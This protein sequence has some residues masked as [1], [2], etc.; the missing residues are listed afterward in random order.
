MVKYYL[1]EDAGS[2]EDCRVV[3]YSDKGRKFMERIR[4][5]FKE[6]NKLCNYKILM[7]VEE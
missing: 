5:V 2:L 7:E 1:V 4:E 6:Q 3:S